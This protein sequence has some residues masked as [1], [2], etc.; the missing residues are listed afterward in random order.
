[1]G[2]E[3]CVESFEQENSGFKMIFGN[4]C[5]NVWEDIIIV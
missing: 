1:M 3:S 4:E 5:T 2:Q